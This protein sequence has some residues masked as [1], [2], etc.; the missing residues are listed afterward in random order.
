MIDRDAAEQ[1]DQAIDWVAQQTA[2]NDV[3]ATTKTA[4]SRLQ[5]WLD[6]PR[7]GAVQKLEFDRQPWRG[8]A[9]ASSTDVIG[10]VTDSGWRRLAMVAADPGALWTIIESDPTVADAILRHDSAE[11]DLRL[12]AVQLRKQIDALE[13]AESPSELLRRFYTGRM[14][15][16]ATDERMAAAQQ[17]YAT[18]TAIAGQIA[19]VAATT[20]DVALGTATRRLIEQRGTPVRPDGLMPKVCILATGATAHAAM[21]YGCPIRIFFLFDSI[22]HRN[23]H[24]RQ[25]FE[26]LAADVVRWIGG[27]P[28]RRDSPIDIDLRDSPRWDFGGQICGLFDAVQI[29]ENSGP[30]GQRLIMSRCVPLAGAVEIGETLIRR[31]RPWIEQRYLRPADAS[32]IRSLVKRLHRR[33]RQSDDRVDPRRGPG[34]LNDLDLIFGL[35]NL[36]LQLNKHDGSLPT[37]QLIEQLRDAGRIDS[38]DAQVLTQRYEQLLRLCNE[39]YLTLGRTDSVLTSDDEFERLAKPIGFDDRSGN[40]GPSLRRVVVQAMQDNLKITRRISKEHLSIDLDEPPSPDRPGRI[41]DSSLAEIRQPSAMASASPVATESVSDAEIVSGGDAANAIGGESSVDVD[42]D[43]TMLSDMLSARGFRDPAAAS[44]QL[45]RMATENIPVLSPRRCKYQF[46]SLIGPL[47]QQI[48]Q[49]P[50]PDQTLS[51]LTSLSAAI[52]AKGTL[53]ETSRR[54]TPLLR[55][56]LRICSA[57]PPVA[58]SLTRRPQWFDRWIDSL[59]RGELP[60]E[61]QLVIEAARQV[62]TA[63]SV[64]EALAVWLQSQCLIAATA[65]MRN[66]DRI[67]RV[68][69]FLWSAQLA[70]VQQALR[71]ELERLAERFGDPQGTDGSPVHPVVLL[72]AADARPTDSLLRRCRLA[73]LYDQSGQTRRRVGGRRHTLSNNEFFERLVGGMM[74]Q[75]SPAGGP[76]V[77][78]V[79]MWSGDRT[80]ASVYQTSTLWSDSPLSTSSLADSASAARIWPDGSLIEKQ[81]ELIALDRQTM[82]QTRDR[83]RKH[84]AAPQRRSSADDRSAGNDA[85]RLE[86]S[87][88]KILN[89]TDRPINRSVELEQPSSAGPKIA[90]A[91][92]LHGKLAPEIRSAA[93]GGGDGRTLFHSLS[94]D[95]LYSRAADCGLLSR[96]LADRLIEHYRNALT[97]RTIESLSIVPAAQTEQVRQA[98]WAF[99]IDRPIE[100]IRDRIDLTKCPAETANDKV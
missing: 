80:H 68:E 62:D 1:I 18:P 78:D 29:L 21:S 9:E 54:S 77:M 3:Q 83:V 35:L 66:P 11:E 52:G 60:T 88:R 56:L 36:Q 61:G 51:R 91:L 46:A 74:A 100:D 96:S 26:T 82:D 65:V 45:Q 86:P 42:R 73:I 59:R 20:L 41:A 12:S 87:I 44:E 50:N 81:F 2:A 16:L 23:V 27:D 15:R 92:D 90:A 70:C 31:L 97:L 79:A 48:A 22:D 99:A 58:E 19:R 84:F 24:Q 5:W 95:Q 57:A 32:E 53:W 43:A 89:A 25:F 55:W 67:S 98:V 75:L 14:V 38:D 64:P 76:R 33:N 13:M 4:R 49:S 69:S 94:I 6:Q 28:K 17:N 34:G 10:G 93:G 47:M 7:Q 72:S 39:V 37:V 71:V 40:V 85:G 63:A 8:F 30:A